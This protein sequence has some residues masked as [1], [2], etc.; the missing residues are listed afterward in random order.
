M[1]ALDSLAEKIAA[2]PAQLQVLGN[3]AALFDLVAPS[4][5]LTVRQVRAL[6]CDAQLFNRPLTAEQVLTL[7]KLLLE[8]ADDGHR[9]AAA[10]AQRLALLEE[11][12]SG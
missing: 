3:L 1:S 5:L 11:L 10:Q 7:A 6:L 9:L 12:S 4:R 2:S 8:G